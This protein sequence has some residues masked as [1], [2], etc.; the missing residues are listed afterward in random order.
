MVERLPMKENLCCVVDGKQYCGGCGWKICKD[1]YA[2]LAN[3][4]DHATQSAVDKLNKA[5]SKFSNC[6]NKII[7]GDTSAVPYLWT[8]IKL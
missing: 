4:P 2:K 5:H 7:L 3:G 1:H 6:P 8:G